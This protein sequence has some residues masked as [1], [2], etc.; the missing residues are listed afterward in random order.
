MLRTTHAVAKRGSE[1]SEKSHYK[2]KND[3]VGLPFNSVP[4]S[5]P[6]SIAIFNICLMHCPKRPQRL[7]DH[8][9]HLGPSNRMVF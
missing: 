7:F 6:F 5:V 1:V 2:R 3:V 8:T 4:I 9:C